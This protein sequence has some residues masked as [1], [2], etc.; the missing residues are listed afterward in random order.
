MDLKLTGKVALVTGASAGIGKAVA[1]ALAEEGCNLIICARNLVRLE[2]V[3]QSIVRSYPKITVTM[4]CANVHKLDESQELVHKSLNAFA[5]ID[6][7]INNSEGA[8]FAD[9]EPEDISDEN[10]RAVFEGK[11]LGYIRMTN[12]VLPRM[13]QRKWGRIINIVGLSGKEP[14]IYLLKAGVT[15]AAL[16]N[17]TKAVAKHAAEHNVLVTS[18]NPGFI[19]TTRFYRFID[20]YSKHKSHDPDKVQKEI[21]KGIPIARVGF[22][23]EVASLISFLSSECASYVTGITIPIDGGFS[24]TAF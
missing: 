6:I 17:F 20:V 1:E 15:N 3:Y 12:L 7:L 18:V 21:V 19:E 11:L 5:Q 23:H 16:I 4:L 10:W 22:P 14:S 13:K 9:E 8:D 24:M 2:E